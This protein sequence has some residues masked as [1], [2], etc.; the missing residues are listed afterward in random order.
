MPKSYLRKSKASNSTIR[1]IEIIFRR[2]WF[3]KRDK[4]AA[5]ERGRK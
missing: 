2:G 4:G 3:S 1:K 5:V